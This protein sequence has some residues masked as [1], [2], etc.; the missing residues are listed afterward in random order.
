M[1]ILLLSQFMSTTKGGG[2][3]VFSIMAKLLSENGH[4]VWIITNRIKN[5]DY[6]KLKNVEFIFVPP[7]LEHKGAL[8]SGLK[9]NFSY[10]FNGMIK[11]KQ[12]IKK[13]KIVLIHSN[14]FTPTFTG[15]MLSYFTGCPHITT[16]HDI[17][18]SYKDFWKLWGKQDK[19]SKVNVFIAKRLEKIMM[20]F[21][22]SAIHTVSESSKEHL[23]K[24]GAKK[25]I[26]VISNAIED[27]EVSQVKI[28]PFHFMYIGRLVFYKNLE[29]I[30]NAIHILKNSY[31]EIKLIIVGSGP[32]KNVLEKLVSRLDLRD[33]VHFSGYVTEEEKRNLLTSSHALLFPSICEGFGIVLLEAFACMKPAIVSDVRPLSDIIEHKKTGLVIPPHD[34][35]EWAK[36][37]MNIIENPSLSVEM[38]RVGKKILKEK[39]NVQN[40]IN[41]IQKMYEEVLSS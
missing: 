36:A 11:G 39:Y 41:N 40:M 27:Y 14:N 8:P 3:Y 34:P 21:R 6:P 33:N 19:I 29:V 2:E 30:I 22:Y 38:G 9:D 28:N 18:G 23:I 12:L 20:R 26:Y 13:H 16:I 5:E 10:F 7:N 24:F 15:S 32:Y 1:N 4:N 37:L 35:N 25:P 31:S 17:Y